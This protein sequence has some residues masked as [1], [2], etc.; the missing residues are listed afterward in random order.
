MMKAAVQHAAEKHPELREPVK[1]I[2]LNILDELFYIFGP[3]NNN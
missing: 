1:F 3:G 2:F